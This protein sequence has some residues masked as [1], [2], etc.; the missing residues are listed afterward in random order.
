MTP[1]QIDYV[2]KAVQNEPQDLYKVSGEL[3]KYFDLAISKTML[4]S[5]LKK[6]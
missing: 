2:D 5:F 6:T 1:E 3:S 4:I